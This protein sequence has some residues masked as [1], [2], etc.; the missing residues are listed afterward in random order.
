VSTWHRLELSQRKELPLRKCLHDIQLW[1]IFSVGDQGRRPHC[2]WDHPWAG[3]L[4]FYKRASWA[5]QGKKASKK[6]PSMASASAPASWPAW[7]PV[8][9]SFSDK[10][11]GGSVSWINHFLH[12]LLLGHDVCAGIE[13]LARTVF[14]V[15]VVFS[16]QNS[17][18]INIY[19]MNESWFTSFLVRRILYWCPFN[20]YVYM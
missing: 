1:S 2:G 14:L 3:S 11:Q 15:D 18:S 10:Q 12:N 20:K 17:S 9:T 7:V 6:H 19:C 4:G 8:L 16:N 5:S 13:T